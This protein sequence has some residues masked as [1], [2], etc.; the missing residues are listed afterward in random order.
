M[1][2]VHYFFLTNTETHVS[3]SL[4]FS[5]LILDTDVKTLL[6][7]VGSSLII[8]KILELFGNICVLFKA[9]INVLTSVVIFSIH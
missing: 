2:Y 8:V 9:S 6:I 7:K 5:V 4:T 3:F 1:E